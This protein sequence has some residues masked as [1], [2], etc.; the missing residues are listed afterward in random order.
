M[1]AKPAQP[2]QNTF[3]DQVEEVIGSFDFLRVHRVMESL[4]WTWANVER[5]PTSAEIE[6]EARRLL[7]EL[8]GRPGVR[9]SGGLRASY[10]ENGTLSLKFILCESW[11]GP[12]EEE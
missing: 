10:K 1:S 11:S 12:G 6:A 3:A 8:E 2:S 4:G 9:G 5:V 7:L